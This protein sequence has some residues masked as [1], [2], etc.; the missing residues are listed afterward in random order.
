M[1]KLNFH[2]IERKWQKTWEES[3]VYNAEVDFTKEKFFVT[4]PF[5]YMSGSVHIG[6]AYTLTRLDVI[7]RFKRHMGYNVLFPFA[8]HWT[9]VTI[10]GVSDRIKRRDQ[11]TIKIL[12]DIDGVPE[13]II[14]KF[15]DPFFMAR[16]FTENNREAIKKLGIGIDWRREFHT[17]SDDQCYSKYVEW[18]YFKLKEGGYIKRGKHPVVW[19]PRCKSVTGDHDRLS[20]EGV[21]PIIFNLVKYKLK[22][23]DAFLVAATLRPETIFGITNVWLNPN[24]DYVEARVNGEKWIVSKSCVEKL[25]DQLR[26]VEV[27]SSF[28]GSLLLGKYVLTPLT[29]KEVPI[30]PASFVDPDLATGVVYSVPAH[31]PY[32]YMALVDLKKNKEVLKKFNLDS[33]I[34]DGLQ[35]IS[36]IKT[37]RFGINPSEVI[38]KE[39]GIQNQNDPNLERATSEVYREEF[40]HGVLLENTGEFKGLLVKDAKVKVAEVLKEKGLADEMLEL[41]TP[42]ICRC[43]TRT[44]VK[45]LPDQYLLDYSNKEWKEKAKRCLSKMRIFPEEARINFEWFIDWYDDWA[46]VRTS[47][48]GTKLPWDDKY[49]IETLSD[50]TIYMAYYIISKFVN[51][52]YLKSSNLTLE[53][54]DYVILGKGN[55][56][57]VARRSNIEESLLESIR[58][59]F[60]YWYP[61]DLR[62]SGKDLIANHLTFY[63]FHHVA[64]FPEDKWPKGIAVNGFMKLGGQPM[65]KS[66]GIFVSIKDA[67]KKYGADVVRLTCLI[68]AD[69]LDDPD[70][71]DEVVNSAF[72]NLNNIYESFLMLSGAKVSENDTELDLWLSSKVREHIKTAITSLNE[73]AIRK[74]AV[75]IFFNFRNTLKRY[76]RRRQELTLTPT[77][78]K[79]LNAWV[80]MM[81]PFTPH[82]AEE[83]WR[84]LGNNSLV[85]KERWPREEDFIENK[86][87]NLKEDYLDS[88]LSDIQNVKKIMKEKPSKIKIFVASEQ[89]RE[90]ARF[91][92]L[93]F[94]E[95]KRDNEIIKEVMVAF[96]DRTSSISYK[97]LPKSVLRLVEK[98]RSMGFD[99]FMNALD[100][101]TEDEF[102]ISSSNFLK[103]DLELEEVKIIKEDSKEAAPYEKAKLSE[104]LRPSFILE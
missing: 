5:P 70:W 49:L 14:Y 92:A 26:D 40:L 52:G 81:A 97:D 67:I 2:E 68:S 79:A 37:E 60:D 22:D 96:K 42:V 91:V 29:G 89:K 32:D 43:G 56:K 12:R 34:V 102:L 45:I 88:L 76:V 78:K 46:F 57:D 66:K 11:Q 74:A 95:G 8:W 83:L 90:I 54:F 17:T 9:G 82:F 48:L 87:A 64:I 101:I 53:F 24:A 65:H 50:S 36:L 31:A 21:F 69:G 18:Q 35:P 15:E 62:N 16:Y 23:S 103:K 51:Q 99:T 47:G 71:N 104:P 86:L 75:E 93:K 13:E 28:N 3:Q 30:L 100:K 84:I 59:E 27:I 20:G 38:V 6:T 25:K 33:S 61:V 10:A 4:F 7:S 72:Q 80:V 58:K 73:V 19:C 98:I 77:L 63:I 94:A 55:P 39:L 44:Y 41:P 85:V 1:Q